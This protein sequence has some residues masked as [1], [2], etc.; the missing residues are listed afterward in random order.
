MGIRPK[1]KSAMD[2]N[3]NR[4]EA[5]AKYYQT[6]QMHTHVPDTSVSTSSHKKVP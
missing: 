5:A 6:L 3:D 1:S 4:P 2:Q